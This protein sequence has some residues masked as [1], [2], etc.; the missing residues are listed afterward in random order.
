MSEQADEWFI[1]E[2]M[3]HIRLAGKVTVDERFGGKLSRIDIPGPKLVD[4]TGDG[5]DTWV[6]QWF[7]AAGVYR[8]TACTEATAREVA[9]FGSPSPVGRWEMR[10]LLTV[11]DEQRYEEAD[12]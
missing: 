12:V 8:I 11:P 6:T 7:G 5:V 1:V 9:A 3:G 10:P 4:S 2:L